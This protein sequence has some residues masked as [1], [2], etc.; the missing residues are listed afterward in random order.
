MSA[1]STLIREIVPLS[2]LNRNVLICSACSNDPGGSGPQRPVS[3]RVGTIFENARRE[4][5]EVFLSVK[6]DFPVAVTELVGFPP[7][8][9]DDPASDEVTQS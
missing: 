9:E 3:L 8:P 5:G 2:V 4:T 6:L 7:R 1:F